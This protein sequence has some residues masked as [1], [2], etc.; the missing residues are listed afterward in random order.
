M[1]RYGRIWIL[2]LSLLI[3][4]GFALSSPLCVLVKAGPFLM[5]N[6]KNHYTMKDIAGSRIQRVELTYDYWIGRY[7]IT[8]AQYDA[9]CQATGRQKPSDR[10][11][12]AG[13]DMGRGDRPVID[14]SWYD[15]IAFCNW[16]S[17]EAGL[18]PAYDNRGNLLDAN[19][20]ITTEISHV[21]GYRLPTE[22]EWEYAARG[23]HKI[24]EDYTYAGSDDMDEVGWYWRNSGERWLL[25]SYESSRLISNRNMIQPVGLK[26]PNALGLHDMSG[27]VAEWCHDWYS[28]LYFRLEIRVNPT[29]PA[30]GSERAVRGGSW[31]YYE[32]FCY[33]STRFQLSPGS[34]RDYVGFRIA[35]TLIP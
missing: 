12:W 32:T 25:G 2:L 23:G 11:S 3:G 1:C 30:W 13:Y 14:V 5:G 34:R 20:M 35:R 28:S 22:A 15:A 29:G 33:I 4:N 19:G 18:S 21:E 31:A 26:K 24:T 8:F 7:E 6:T 17:L 27:N 9:F 10:S 16:L